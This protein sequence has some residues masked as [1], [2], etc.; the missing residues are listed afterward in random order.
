MV[1]S[2]YAQ[3]GAAIQAAAP[4]AIIEVGWQVTPYQP[5]VVDRPITIVGLGGQDQDPVVQ[6]GSG[7]GITFALAPGEHATIA[8]LDVRQAL[9]TSGGQGA[10]VNAGMVSFEECRFSGFDDPTGAAGLAAVDA[11]DCDLAFTNCRVEPRR[12]IAG[13]HALRS[14]VHAVSSRFFGGSFLARDGFVATDSELNAASSW[15]QGGDAISGGSGGAGLVLNGTSRA[16]LVEPNAIGGIGAAGGSGIVNNTAVP[17]DTRGGLFH[18][19]FGTTPSGNAPPFTGPHQ[20][21]PSL[22]GLGFSAD[23]YRR[24]TLRPGQSFGVSV[25]TTPGALAML[26]FGF[27]LSGTSSPFTRQ[28]AMSIAEVA[29]A[30]PVVGDPQG[31]ATYSGALPNVPGLIG[32]AVSMQGVGGPSFPLAATPLGAVVVR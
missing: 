32:T 9:G 23:P 29:F 19:G 21:D 22:L 8:R 24:G 30:L 12:G 2:Q 26:A 17:I 27:G 7:V 6:V 15:F 1:P 14:R 11:A 20:V 5:F 10:V 3:I 18:G 31:Y 13:L 16:W 25:L 4:G 28:P